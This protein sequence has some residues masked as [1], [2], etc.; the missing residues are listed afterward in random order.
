MKDF[1]GNVIQVGDFLAYPGGGN[2]KGQYGLLLKKVKK[3]HDDG[4]TVE[5]I[6]VLYAGKDEIEVFDGPEFMVKV[7]YS[8]ASGSRTEDQEVR[9][10]KLS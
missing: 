10:E 9:P 7:R 8:N 4:V 2:S 1:I 5:G 3:I 6:N